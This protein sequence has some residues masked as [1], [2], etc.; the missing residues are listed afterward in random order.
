MADVR[1]QTK[2]A[3]TYAT[4]NDTDI[5]LIDSSSGGTV[6]KIA[7]SELIKKILGGDITAGTALGSAVLKL[8]AD[9]K[10]EGMGGI[11]MA[12]N[13]APTDE[14]DVATKY[15]VD[16]TVNNESSPVLIYKNSFIYSSLNDEAAHTVVP[17]EANAVILGIYVNVTTAFTDSGTDN[18]KIGISTD[19]DYF[20]ATIDCS[21]TGWKDVNDANFPYKSTG[22]DSVTITYAGQNDDA[23]A[24]NVEVYVHYAR[25]SS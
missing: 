14:N 15:Y 22:A 24:G 11:E 21:T 16:T 12:S 6:R 3:A 4:V 13:Y 23:D 8:D 18:L 19:D 25:F 10:V 20:E 17:I 2:S 1:L 5:F 7:L 9:K